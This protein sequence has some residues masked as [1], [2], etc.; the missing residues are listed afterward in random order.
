MRRP[1][2]LMVLT[3][4]AVLV[5]T[6]CSKPGL[7]DVMDGGSTMEELVQKHGLDQLVP[8]AH[9]DYED[10]FYCASLSFKNRKF[11]DHKIGFYSKTG[12]TLTLIDKQKTLGGFTGLVCR[13]ADEVGLPALVADFPGGID[14]EFHFIRDGQLT[15]EVG[16]PERWKTIE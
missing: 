15:H 3:G 11:I 13:Y 10:G 14:Q 8:L 6:G 4:L 16:H 12:D 7:P 9:P 1:A 5:S 2:R